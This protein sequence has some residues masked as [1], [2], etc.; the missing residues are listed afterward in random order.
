VE[1]I[2]EPL[3]WNVKG[4]SSASQALKL[5]CSIGRK[6]KIKSAPFLNSYRV[7][8]L[9]HYVLRRK[10]VV[11]RKSGR[12]DGVAG[13]MVEYVTSSCNIMVRAENHIRPSRAEPVFSLDE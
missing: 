1:P 8:L 2:R 13:S 12:L 5:A 9:R 10:L 11:P 6:S 7:V 3:V 4:C